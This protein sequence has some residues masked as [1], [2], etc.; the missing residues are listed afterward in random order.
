MVKTNFLGETTVTKIFCLT[1]ERA[2]SKKSM[3]CLN[4]LIINYTIIVLQS[5]RLTTMFLLT[6]SVIDFLMKS[7][8]LTML[9]VRD[10]FKIWHTAEG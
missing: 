10:P 6:F 2:L 7:H 1:C 4:T 8:Q 5:I 9:K 3:V